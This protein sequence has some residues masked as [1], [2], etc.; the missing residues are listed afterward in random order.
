MRVSGY[1]AVG[2]GVLVW[3]ALGAI[4]NLDACCMRFQSEEEITTKSPLMQEKIS[5]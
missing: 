2:S 1:P 5:T 3:G 4:I